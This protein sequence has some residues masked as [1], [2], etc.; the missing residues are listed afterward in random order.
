[1]EA[2]SGLSVGVCV[3]VHVFVC[4]P[5]YKS[6]G[7][8]KCVG[9]CKCFNSLCLGSGVNPASSC[10]RGSDRQWS[11]WRRVLVCL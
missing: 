6:M 3:C 7:V 4:V 10:H 8:C 1:M 5:A 11:I 9:V 2:C